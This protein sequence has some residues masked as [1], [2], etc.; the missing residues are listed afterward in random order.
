MEGL[1]LPHNKGLYGYRPFPLS[2]F[3]TAPNTFPRK[4]VSNSASA[5]LEEFLRE[6]T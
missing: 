1:D 6:E 4:S 2:I 5:G 3:F